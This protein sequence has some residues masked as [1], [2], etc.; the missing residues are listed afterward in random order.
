MR[1]AQKPS[2]LEVCKQVDAVECFLHGCLTDILCCIV[3]GTC[4][5][6]VPLLISCLCDYYGH[7]RNKMEAG[8]RNHGSVAHCSPLSLP[9]GDNFVRTTTKL[10]NTCRLNCFGQGPEHSNTKYISFSVYDIVNEKIIIIKAIL[11][12]TDIMDDWQCACATYKTKLAGHS[13]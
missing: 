1:A 7:N 3:W 13:S 4:R 11:F 12:T 10:R 2:P 6:Y 5:N 8:A 9:C